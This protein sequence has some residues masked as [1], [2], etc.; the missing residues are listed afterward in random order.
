M[1]SPL[2]YVEEGAKIGKNVTIQPFAYV[3][4]DVEIGD[5][6]EIM[7]YASILNGTRMGKNNKIHHHAVLG[8]EPQDFKYKGGATNLV[9]G[10]D[11]SIRENVVISRSSTIGEATII[12]NGNFLMDKVHLCHDV[13]I[14]NHCVVGICTTVAGKSVLDDCVILSGNVILHQHCHVASWSLIQSGCRIN[15]DVPPFVIM[16]E[17]PAAYH[18]VNSLILSKQ[19]AMPENI[20]RHIVS[21]YRLIYQG[22]FSMEDAVKRIEEEIPMS[23][24]IQMI[25][26]FVKGSKLGIVK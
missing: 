3:E 26:D 25:L 19:C 16:S 2:A 17:N 21:A 7:S 12:G 20:L 18:G 13:H 14:G 1:I 4:K 6:C 11:N 22:H 15:K 5:N 10:D 9:I 8:A 23:A 24:E